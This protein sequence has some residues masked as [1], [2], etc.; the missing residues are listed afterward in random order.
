MAATI[1][2]HSR[3]PNARVMPTSTDHTCLAGMMSTAANIWIA[4]RYREILKNAELAQFDQ[5]MNTKAGR[6]LRVLPDR[7]NWY[8]QTT[9]GMYLKKHRARTW[10][11]WI[12][13]AL[14]NTARFWGECHNCRERPLQRSVRTFMERHA[15]HSPQ[16]VHAPFGLASSPSPGRI[17]AENALALQSLG[18]DVMPLMAYGEKLH[19]DGRLESFLLS[20]ELVGYCE[21]QDF[22]QLRFPLRNNGSP[23]E[24]ALRRLIVQ[25][26][27]IA[28]RFHAAGFNHRDFYCCH[29]LVKE[30]SP[31]QFD[32]RL[33]DLQRVQQRRWFRRRWIVKDL[34]QLVSMSPDDRVGCREKILFLRTYLGVR[35][36]RPQDKRLVHD[37]L[38]KLSWIRRRTRHKP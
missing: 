1:A 8:L 25:V 37:V 27:D 4:E 2:M 20:E 17:E 3:H 32:V 24:P 19:A 14:N 26:A 30:M 28:R 33:I 5:V 22:I 13:A 9:F 23:L 38:W 6:C 12:V 21:L 10:A 31:D 18:I 15:G 11:T 29:F 16:H 7:E 36:L 34:A 35:K